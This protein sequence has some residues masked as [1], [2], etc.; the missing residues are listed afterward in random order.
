MIADRFTVS[1]D[2]TWFDKA[3]VSLVEEEFGEEKNPLVACGSDAYFVDFLRDA[4]EA[5]GK[6]LMQNLKFHK[7]VPEDRRFRLRM[8]HFW[9][10]IFTETSPGRSSCSI[11][12]E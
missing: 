3:L 5:T 12:I 4:P 2:V 11:N 9:L 7:G 8:L 1:S 10:G 6:L